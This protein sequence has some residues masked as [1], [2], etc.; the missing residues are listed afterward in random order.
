VIRLSLALKTAPAVEPIT[1]QQAKDFCRADS[2]AIADNLTP[3][4][5]IK[6]GSQAVGA[7]TYDLVG[8][9]V[10]VLG[11]D[12]LVVLSAGTFTTGT[13]DVKI[14]ES[15]DGTT[16]TDWTGGAFAQVKNTNDEQPYEIAYTG[17]KRYIRAVAKVLVAVCPFD[18]SVVL[19]SGITTEDTLITSLIK[20]ARQWV[21][22]YLNRQ[23]ITAT[24]YLYLDAFPAVDYI[25]LPLPPL[26]SVTAITYTDTDGT[27]HTLAATEYDVDTY[28]QWAP[29]V[30][31]KYGK[32]WPSTTLRPYNGVCVEFVCGYGATAISVPENIVNACKMRLKELW[33]RGD[34]EPS[35]AIYALLS[36]ER[37]IAI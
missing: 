18:V 21:E 6:P 11:Y 14:Q 4:Q 17:S 34:A 13:A 24:W 2:G 37:V 26:Q 20:S 10:D 19:Q 36:S 12:P 32:S 33:E 28:D 35:P 9:A 16:W 31:L 22:K 27:A 29:K 25:R 7:G 1:L 23:L 5:S 30:S 3:S 15:D 8:A